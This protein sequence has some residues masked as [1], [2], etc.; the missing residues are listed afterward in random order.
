METDYVKLKQIKPALSGY[1]RKAQSLIKNSDINDADTVHDIRVLMKK[2]RAVLKLTAH[3]DNNIYYERDIAGLR[4]VGRILCCRRDIS[5]QRKLLRGLRKEFPGIFDHLQDNA[6]LNLFLQKQESSPE[7]HE[8]L[9]KESGKVEDILNKTNFRIRFQPMNL[10]DPQLLLK[11]LE[12]SYLTVADLFLRCRNNPKPRTLHEFRKKAKD[13]MYQ[14][15]IFRPLNPSK[16]KDLEKKMD[17]IS[18][19]LGRFNDL[20]QIIKTL[21]Y[22]YSIGNN[23]PALDELVVKIR[24]IQDRFIGRVW[25]DSSE[26]FCPGR[27]LVNLLGFKLLV[28]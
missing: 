24:E 7:S 26:I 17:S 28:I 8:E 9:K 20:V 1:I 18:Q 25:F 10:I 12:L 19:N 13:F 6:R 4:E 14:L 3:Q 2:A 16:V 15:Y 27:K 23:Q 11:E 5:V 21:D 22:K